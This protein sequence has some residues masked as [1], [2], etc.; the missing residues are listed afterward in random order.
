[1]LIMTEMLCAM[2]CRHATGSWYA[3]NASRTNDGLLWQC[4]ATT[5]AAETTHDA[6]IRCALLSAN[7]S[8]IMTGS[9][10]EQRYS[11]AFYSRKTT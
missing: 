6:I 7:V 2:L 3:T 8:M 4:S 5:N 10:T 1:M 11:T 9:F